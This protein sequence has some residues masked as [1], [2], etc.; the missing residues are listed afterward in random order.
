MLQNSPHAPCQEGASPSND[1]AE[2][3]GLVTAGQTSFIPSLALLAG[4]QPE[5]PAWGLLAQSHVGGFP[6]K[7]HK[8]ERRGEASLIHT[9][10]RQP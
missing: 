7:P 6:W 3:V 5:L 9:P 8:K 1:L 10:G 4:W 2:H